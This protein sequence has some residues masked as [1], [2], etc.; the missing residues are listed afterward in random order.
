MELGE[1]GEA[2]DCAQPIVRLAVRR[3]GD[4]ELQAVRRLARLAATVRAAELPSTRSLGAALLLAAPAP[5]VRLALLRAAFSPLDAALLL[6]P[7]AAA[8]RD[9]WS[10]RGPFREP[11]GWP[12]STARDAPSDARASPLL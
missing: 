8:V 3:A 12:R 1:G 4:L 7:P 10:F 9:G 5:A 2:G 6:A 11:C